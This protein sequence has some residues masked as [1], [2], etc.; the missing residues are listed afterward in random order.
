MQP[1][2][3]EDSLVDNEGVN[4]GSDDEQLGQGAAGD[5]LGGGHPEEFDPDTQ[6]ADAA[7]Q[8]GELAGTPGTRDTDT[9]QDLGEAGQDVGLMEGD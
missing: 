7:Q 6:P 1:E 5:V 3:P 9:A 2:A 8:T 4:A